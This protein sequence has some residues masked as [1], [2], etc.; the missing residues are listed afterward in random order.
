[1]PTPRGP[2]PSSRL[3]D[4]PP[5]VRHSLPVRPPVQR[6][7]AAL[8]CCSIAS[9]RLVCSSSLPSS[10]EECRARLRAVR[11]PLCCYHCHCSAT[12]IGDSERSPCDQQTTCKTD[13][14]RVITTSP[15]T[16]S[17]RRI[18]PPRAMLEPSGY[19]RLDDSLDKKKATAPARTCLVFRAP[20]SFAL[21]VAS[22]S[23]RLPGPAALQSRP[24]RPEPTC[25][26]DELALPLPSVE[27]TR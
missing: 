11:Q 7:T 3:I 13:Q 18:V 1:M 23:P 14:P 20:F 17:P 5:A 15:P 27:H 26:T 25:C 19:S 2:F 10:A 9:H 8:L 22:S 16:S 24:R 4:P 12:V 21:A 6:T